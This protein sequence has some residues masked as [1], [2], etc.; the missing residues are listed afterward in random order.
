MA[1]IEAHRPRDVDWKRAAALLYGGDVCLAWLL[2]GRELARRGK[3][4]WPRQRD[5]SRPVTPSSGFHVAL[6]LA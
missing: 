1:V 2:F 5:P 4:D 6:A 3:M